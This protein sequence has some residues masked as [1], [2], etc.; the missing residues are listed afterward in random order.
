MVDP[1]EINNEVRK[2]K[3]NLYD[4]TKSKSGARI[5]T[6][7]S[8]TVCVRGASDKAAPSLKSKKGVFWF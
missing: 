8:T 2:C 1:G 6:R 3:E 4:G 5:P 7:R